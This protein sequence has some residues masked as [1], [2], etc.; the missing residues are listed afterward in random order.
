MMR[1]AFHL[2]MYLYYGGACKFLGS[3]HWRRL[4]ERSHRE[5][6][7]GEDYVSFKSYARGYKKKKK[8]Y[9]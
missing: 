7:S 6:R 3:H 9:V 4:N 1:Y 5:R 8:F 2:N